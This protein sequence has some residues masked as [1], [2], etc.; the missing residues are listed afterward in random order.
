MAFR[1][2]SFFNKVTPAIS[3][4]GGTWMAKNAFENNLKSMIDSYKSLTDQ[5]MKI[6][7]PGVADPNAIDP[8]NAKNP[9]TST[10]TGDIPVNP[11]AGN[12]IPE[13]Q[14]NTNTNYSNSVG[15]PPKVDNNAMLNFYNKSMS[16]IGNMTANPYDKGK[17]SG[18]LNDMYTK[19]TTP[20]KKDKIYNSVVGKDGSMY[21]MNEVTGKMEKVKGPDA[22][23]LIRDSY[24]TGSNEEGFTEHIV[25]RDDQGNIVKEIG[26]NYS[27]EE[28]KKTNGSGYRGSSTGSFP[29]LS[30]KDQAF[31]D[32]N[33]QR[34]EALKNGDL[35]KAK[36]IE[37]QFPGNWTEFEAAFDK[38]STNPIKSKQY[39]QDA[40]RNSETANSTYTGWMTNIGADRWIPDMTGANSM[41]DLY[42]K[43]DYY[44]KELDKQAK[45]YNMPKEVYDYIRNEIS[46]A[47]NKRN[48]KGFGR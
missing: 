28:P 26:T 33:I 34:K 40:V 20:E 39:I 14:G 36:E 38:F 30:N 15:I 21:T 22:K 8:R 17:F 2:D 47:Y 23:A 46:D 24:V 45:K 16:A 27:K 32:A 1:W 3:D 29:T 6:L 48:A 25:M 19:L 9:V 4:F 41:Q 13:S 10:P 44:A 43:Y 12:P 11:N 35:E 31:I 42:G 18:A 37:R 5:N 7:N